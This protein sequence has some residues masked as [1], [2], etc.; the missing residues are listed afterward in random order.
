MPGGTRPLEGTRSQTAGSALRESAYAAA[1]RMRAEANAP[2]RALNATKRVSGR[3]AGVSAPAGGSSGSASVTPSNGAVPDALDRAGGV[4]AL[5]QHDR[6]ERMRAWP[7][8]VRIALEQHVLAVDEF[9]RVVG[10]G[11]W[12]R[13]IGC[14]PGD[15][16]HARGQR[17]EVGQRESFEEVRRRPRQRD[18]ERRAVDL[19]PADV[20]RAAR[21]VGAC[22]EDIAEDPATGGS[23]TERG[24]EGVLDT[25]AEALRRDRLAGGRREPVA[26]PDGERVGAPVGRERGHRG[27]D[28]RLQA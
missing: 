1:R 14:A 12:W 15:V 11:R 5:A 22:A 23:V 7:A 28:L 24:R 10:A 25:A 20:W 4:D 6:I 27:G 18:P 26:R 19:E 21:V 3:T 2:R 13:M 8:V 16:R 9:R 17:R